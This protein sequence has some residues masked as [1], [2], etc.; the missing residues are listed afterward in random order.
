MGEGNRGNEGFFDGGGEHSTVAF[1]ELETFARQRILIAAAAIEKHRGRAGMT[2]FESELGEAGIVAGPFVEG[3][4]GIVTGITE[5]NGFQNA[6]RAENGEHGNRMIGRTFERAVLDEF[7]DVLFRIVTPINSETGEAL[8]GSEANGGEIGEGFAGG[9][10]DFLFETGRIFVDQLDLMVV[11]RIGIV[12]GVP[13]DGAAMGVRGGE[14]DL[15]RFEI[16]FLFESSAGVLI[17]AL[18]DA[19]SV[20]G[21][22]DSA[23]TLGIFEGEDF[24]PKV[25]GFAYGRIG[26]AGVT[27]EPH[28][29]RR[30]DVGGGDAG[31]PGAL[32]PNPSPIRWARETVADG[33]GKREGCRKKGEQEKMRN[34]PPTDDF[35]AAGE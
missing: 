25:H 28:G 29:L 24:D 4:G 15:M 30:G 9:F 2:F 13:K 17:D 18:R 20:A 7:G 35:G 27:G 10:D 19:E 23:V 26:A 1:G 34:D 12:K 21:H 33:G 11:E 3:E 5:E 22:D 32:T 31:E 16:E 8:A 6:V 14:E